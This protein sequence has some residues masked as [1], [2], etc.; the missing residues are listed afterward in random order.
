MKAVVD[1]RYRSPFGVEG[2]DADHEQ[3]AA[4]SEEC[5]GEM[6]PDLAVGRCVVW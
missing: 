1:A 6:M 4:E 2:Y 3:T 5:A